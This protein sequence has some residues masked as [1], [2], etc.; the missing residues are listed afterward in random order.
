MKKCA[1]ILVCGVMLSAGV[2]HATETG[3][4]GGGQPHTNMQPSRAVNYIIALDGPVP[5]RGEN[6]SGTYTHLGQISMF[7]GDFAPRGWAFCDGQLLTVSQNDALFGLLGTIYGG[8]GRTTFGLP[9]LRG[10]AP[11]HAGQ[12]PKLTDRRLGWRGGD[13]NATLDLGQMAAHGHPL[14][15]GGV[16]DGEGAG[17]PHPNMQ[18]SLALNYNIA[19]MGLS[20]HSGGNNPQRFLGEVGIFAG[21]FAPGGTEPLDGALL[22]FTQNPSMFVLLGTTYGGDGR[23]TFGLPD[24]RGRAPIHTGRGPGLTD[25]PL[26]WKGGAEDS[27]LVHTQLPP[28][29]HTLPPTILSTGDT[30]HSQPHN[31]MQPSLALNYMIAL[32]GEE[33]QRE[34]GANPNDAFLGKISIFSADFAPPGWALCN[35]QLL[36]ISQNDALF[37]LL[38]TTYGGDG[39]TTFGLPDLRGR[40]PIHEGRGPTLTDRWLGWHGGVEGVILSESRIPDHDHTYS[41]GPYHPGDADLDGDVDDDD[42]SLLLAGWGQN[43]DWSHGEFDGV[44]PVDDSDLSLLL[45]HWTGSAAVPEPATL[46]LVAV[47]APVL[48]RRNRRRASE[49]PHPP[50]A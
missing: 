29:D 27:T 5:E 45:A 14:P 23:T 8:D 15:W 38:G 3:S 41:D 9:D 49:L 21:D 34:G 31:N 16:T 20:P 39:R 17:A 33:P 47:G 44:P 2:S 13:E 24:L 46:G 4:V 32:T 48:L 35:G 40:I 30:G 43:T 26:G 19:T 28:H 7:A 50:E 22:Q 6:H 25:R 18:P 12:G 37:S 10:R 42:L 36:Q 11:L 1:A